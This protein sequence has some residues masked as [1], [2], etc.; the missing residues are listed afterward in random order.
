MKCMF[1]LVNICQPFNCQWFYSGCIVSII[2]DCLY[3]L[4]NILYIDG[5]KWNWHV[6]YPVGHNLP[7]DKMNRNKLNWIE[8]DAFQED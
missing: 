3:V 5:V 1:E 4:Y 8:Y 2:L 6:L 7:L